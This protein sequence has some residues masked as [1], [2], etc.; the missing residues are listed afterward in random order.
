MNSDT[1]VI[2]QVRMALGRTEA[3]KAAP[4][5]PAIDEPITRLVHSEIGLPDLFAK[6]AE[7]NNIQ[8]EMAPPE[9]LLEKL[10]AFLRE[11]QCRKV[12]LSV[13]PF[14]DGLGLPSGLRAAGF[15][16]RAWDELTA[17]ALFDYDCGVTD[18]WC[19]VAEVGAL[20]IRPT[21]QHGRAISLAPPLH[22]AIL[23]PRD[24]VP[25][26]VDLF[27]KMSRDGVGSGVTIIT[28]PSKT[29]DIE[30]NLVTGV[31]GPKAVHVFILQ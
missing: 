17:D 2:R 27:E 4:V 18:A 25:D 22:V 9:D 6:R 26:L 15:E 5:P 13:S 23:Q 21:P 1:D 10:T 8:V 20:V 19:A 29:A 30:M 11:Q 14:L 24:F 16:A 7:L 28:G 3:L 31:H 12:A